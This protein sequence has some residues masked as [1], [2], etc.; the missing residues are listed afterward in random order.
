[1]QWGRVCSGAGHGDG[2]KCPGWDPSA[3]PYHIPTPL[4]HL[5][6]PFP[7]SFLGPWGAGGCSFWGAGPY[8]AVPQGAVEGCSMGF[9][10]FCA[11]LL[12]HPDLELQA[13]PR[14]VL[15]QVQYSSC[16]LFPM[17][18]REHQDYFLVSPL[19]GASTLLAAEMLVQAGALLAGQLQ[20][21]GTSGVDFV[22]LSGLGSTGWAP[23]QLDHA[24]CCRL[25]HALPLHRQ[26][27]GPGAGTATPDPLHPDTADLGCHS[28][29]TGL[30]PDPRPPAGE[31]GTPGC[32]SPLGNRVICARYPL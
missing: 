28:T 2:W 32:W 18:P 29:A 27:G 5:L 22:S 3:R 23:E 17:H 12:N 26:R 25:P 16:S 10:K 1:M 21:P 6:F 13:I 8:T 9:T 30:G 20:V 11:A 24:P 4:S 15:E 14:A 7:E 31:C 19:P